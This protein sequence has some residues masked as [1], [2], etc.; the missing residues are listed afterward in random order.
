M[1]RIFATLAFLSALLLSLS[2]PA[3]PIDDQFRA[4]LGDDL[5]PEAK[6]QGSSRKTFDAAFDGVKPNLK[7]PDLVM[8]GEKPT[9]PRKQEQAEFGSPERRRI[10]QIVFPSEAEAKAA[11]DRIK[12]GESFEAIAKE[13]GIADKD[14]ELGTFTKGELF[15]E[16]VAN[17]AFGLPEQDAPDAAG[18]PPAGEGGGAWLQAP[19]CAAP[20]ASHGC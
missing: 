6:A 12:A 5:W 16:A 2:A 1:S 13:R 18:A 20:R 4:W 8:P 15:D 10:Q 11:S 3:A 19:R 7:L 14:L 17:A 9:K